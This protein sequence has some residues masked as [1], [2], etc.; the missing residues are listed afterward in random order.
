M[1]AKIKV[2]LALIAIIV[3]FGIVGKMEFE[4]LMRLEAMQQGANYAGLPQPE[5][6]FKISH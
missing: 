2:A 5:I 3:L 4:D 1:M 6:S